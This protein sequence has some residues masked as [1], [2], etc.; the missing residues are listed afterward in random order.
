MAAKEL[1]K[2]DFNVTNDCNFRCIHCCFRSGM[3]NLIDMPLEKIKTVLDEFVSIGGRRIDI[4]GGEPMKRKDILEIIR[5]AKSLKIKTELVTNSSLLRDVHFDALMAVGLD[6]IAISLD[7]STCERYSAIR[8]VNDATYAQVL[9]NIKK[10]VHYGFNTKI[11]TVVFK[12]NLDDM[13]NIAKQ[14]IDLG[15]HEHGFYFFS[16]IGS[17]VMQK[18]NV[19]DPLAWLNIIRTELY[20]MKDL[21]EYSLETPVIETDIVIKNGL[22][23]GCYMQ[24]PWHLQILPTGNIYPCAIMAT[25]DRPI[26]NLFQ[27]DL[28]SVWEDLKRNNIKYYDKNI[29]PLFSNYLSCVPYPESIGLIESCKYKFACLCTKFKIE[30]LM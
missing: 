5:Y 16:P 26:A 22:K 20:E 15:A 25:Y 18:D 30:E 6:A 11:N 19:A 9:L 8:N 2:L 24:D 3:Q 12:S 4:T 1:V 28:K 23:T 21:I 27:E 7:G 29:L 13:V 14:A 10:S 17:G